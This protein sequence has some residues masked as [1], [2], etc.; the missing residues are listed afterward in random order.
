MG[1]DKKFRFFF[2]AYFAQRIGGGADLIPHAS[3]AY[4]RVIV[5]Y[6]F[7]FA[8]YLAD[9]SIVIVSFWPA[10]AKNYLV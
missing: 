5:P 3:H 2:T 4:N 9:H 10:I 1:M 6:V 8:S 7:K